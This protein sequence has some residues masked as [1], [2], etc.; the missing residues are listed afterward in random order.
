MPVISLLT[1]KVTG[2]VVANLFIREQVWDFGGGRG[3]WSRY[4]ELRIVHICI[5]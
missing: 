1:G 3:K 2:N 5:D 4:I